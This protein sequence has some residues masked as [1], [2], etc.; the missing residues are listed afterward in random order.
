MGLEHPWVWVLAG[1]EHRSSSSVSCKRELSLLAAP[2]VLSQ[3]EQQH[4]VPHLHTAAWKTP[5]W[6]QSEEPEQS[7]LLWSE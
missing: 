5:G 2:T 4:H 3:A 7:L 6:E 1:K